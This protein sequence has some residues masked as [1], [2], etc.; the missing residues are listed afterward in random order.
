[1]RQSLNYDARLLSLSHE[2]CTPLLLCGPFCG[3]VG[4]ANLIAVR[5]RRHRPRRVFIRVWGHESFRVR[6]I[7][8]ETTSKILLETVVD[9]S[10]MVLVF[11]PVR[12]AERLR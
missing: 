10:E 11:S 5:R 6:S 12:S 3:W 9:D 1:M 7:Q 2:P 8:I 4:A